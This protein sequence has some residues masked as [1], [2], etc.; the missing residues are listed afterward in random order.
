MR[1]LISTITVS[2]LLLTG[3][4]Q[5][6]RFH[7]AI[8]STGGDV[9]DI[10][11]DKFG[12][13]WMANFGMGLQRYDGVNLK[14]YKS[15]Q[16]NPG[17]TVPGSAISVGIDADNNI[18][19]GTL[20][21][22]QKFEPTTNKFTQYRH[23]PNDP[24]SISSDTV[25][26]I[27]EDHLGNLWV[28]TFRGLDLLDKKTGKFT[29]YRNDPNDPNSIGSSA[30]FTLFEDKKGTLWV[31]NLEL[32]FVPKAGKS[33]LSR[34]DRSTGK[35]TRFTYDPANPKGIQDNRVVS[36]YEDNKGRF[37]IITPQPALYLMDRDAGVFTRYYPD[38]TKAGPLSAQPG[39][40]KLVSQISFISEDSTGALW[41]GLGLSGMH[42]Y[43]ASGNKSTH[44]GYIHEGSKQ[45]SGK[46]T[47]SGF[48]ARQANRA[49]SSRDGL[50]WVATGD[51]E[52]YN[53]NY[54][55][56]NIPFYNIPNQISGGANSF[57]VE[58]NGFILWIT[59][60]NGLLRR[61]MK[62]NTDKVWFNN[63]K[64][65][66]S[67][68]HN[69]IS[70]IR[71]D[72][73]GKFWLGTNGGG[74]DKF[75]PVSGKFVNY[76]HDPGNPK[77][78][79]GHYFAFLFIDHSQ[80]LWCAHDSGISRMNTR[81][82][83]FINYKHNYKDSSSIS[84]NNVIGIAEDA[85]GY[86]WAASDK[87]MLRLDVKSG[88]F[89]SYI[90]SNNV[91]NICIDSKGI[92]WAGSREALYYYNKTKD[93]FVLF[94][95]E[96]SIVPISN[97]INIIEDDQKNLWVST[98]NQI[99]K[100]N[101]DRSK[102]KKYTEA[103][104]VRATGFYFNDNFKAKDGKLFLGIENGYYSFYP[105]Q[106]SD[107][108][109]TPA[110]A[111]FGF[112]LGDREVVPAPN[113]ILTAPIWQTE[114]VRLNHH[115]NVFSFDFLA[116]DF[117]TPNDEKYMFMLENY[118]NT[119]HD[120]GGDH[121][122][123]FF[124]VPPGKYNFRVKAINSDGASAE[125]SIR[126][127][128][129]PPWWRTW[130]AYCLYG[131][132]LILVGYLIYKYQRYYIVKRE[133]ER[134]QQKELA[135]AKEIEKAYTELK[136]TQAQL[137]QSEKMAS[138]GELTAGIAHEIQN[139]LNFVNNF[140]EVN[141]EL[142]DE[143]TTELATGNAQQA[144]EIANNIKSNEEKI[145]YHGKRADSIVKGMLQHSRNNSGQK[146]LTDINALTDECMRLS[147]H[148]LRAKDKSFNAKTTTIFDETLPKVNM[149]PQDIG[150]VVLN[151]FTN[152]FYSVMQKKKLLGDSFDPT[153]T[154]KTSKTAKGISISIRDNGNGIPQKVIDKIFQP[155]F[156]TKPV[157]EG[158]GLGLSMSY[159]IITKG[160]GGE[161]KV[162]SQ[163]GEFAEFIIE[164]PI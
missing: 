33:G 118:D 108:M 113:G 74:L 157:G 153:V 116:V 37:W 4:T 137:I 123:F 105:N 128:I 80:N 9:F 20:N 16:R 62:T 43:D 31:G 49:M 99:I 56:T 48:T 156:T 164:L 126:I 106:I 130:W 26:T 51:G 14:S 30:A 6:I 91:K 36:I 71:V 114:E 39:G 101:E 122:A 161:L 44:F 109:Y 61:D 90:T 163:E 110:L 58:P 133:R 136:N 75:D 124:N 119:W 32:D 17:T 84:T 54:N 65:A 129:S 155:F 103:N 11:Q 86:I 100:I 143:L 115:Q 79:S 68:S 121:R 29:H 24:S 38:P 76:R 139:P 69:S 77:S 53:L 98:G 87:G 112:K 34:F 66:N 7:E 135:Q 12:V 22:L 81:T 1:K 27:L 125:K 120:L 93:E 97:V 82:G 55:K 117:I 72:A 149:A 162:N 50:F 154:A 46:D 28:G 159:D 107:I 67:V 127:I 131:L 88:K 145:N 138:L 92:M 158:T 147:Y 19:V 78:L 83:E 96:Q 25:G 40:E 151:L 94:A 10:K 2:F 85:D 141:T 152:A 160:H 59:T 8:K 35:F 148:G 21:G 15:D 102:V 13:I 41:I 134:S 89:R 60:G 146:E 73:E 104:G 42:R 70:A 57:Y 142:I 150:R 132:L 95:D 47:A 140:S 18:W 63:P 5:D 64:D 144:I 45:I 3:Y 52:L 111:I 23:N